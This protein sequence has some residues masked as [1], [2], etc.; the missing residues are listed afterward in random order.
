MFRGG[1]ICITY[2]QALTILAKLP[3]RHITSLF[4][5]P[6]QQI[7]GIPVDQM[8]FEGN[9]LVA[10]GGVRGSCSPARGLK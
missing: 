6:T 10:V 4:A 8:I 1:A 9:G 2:K 7:F 5:Q 3:P